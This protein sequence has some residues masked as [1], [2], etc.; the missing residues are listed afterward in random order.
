MTIA[1]LLN[2]LGCSVTVAEDGTQAVD[3]AQE[4]IYD[5][6]L[7]DYEMPE[8]DGLST[9]RIIRSREGS[10]SSIP[11]IALTGHT[12]PGDTDAFHSAGIDDHLGKPV[13]GKELLEVLNRW[14]GRKITRK[15][16]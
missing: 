6:V 5:L 9:A 11:I 4:D 10:G 14:A 8:M 15:E 13:Q 2:K 3:R 16:T 1:R 7:L 12:L